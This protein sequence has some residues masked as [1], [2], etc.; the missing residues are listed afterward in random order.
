MVLRDDFEAA[1]FLRFLVEVLEA[2]G[3]L[4]GD[5][6]GGQG[7]VGADVGQFDFPAQILGAAQEAA[8]GDVVFHGRQRAGEGQ[9]AKGPVAQEGHA[10]AHA[11]E[12]LVQ[13]IKTG[14]VAQGAFGDAGGDIGAGDDG[15]FNAGLEVQAVVGEGTVVA[16]AGDGAAAVGITDGAVERRVK[17]LQ[18]FFVFEQGLFHSP[19]GGLDSGVVLLCRQHEIGQFIGMN[20]CNQRSQKHQHSTPKRA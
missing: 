12:G 17:E 4:A 10:H 14:R 9:S 18:Q 2:G 6:V 7:L 5:L 15:R 16:A 13:V 20:R 1:E 8:D 3:G 11:E 19:A